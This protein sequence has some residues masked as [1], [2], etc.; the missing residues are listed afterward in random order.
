M[1]FIYPV[2]LTRHEDGS[3]TGEFPDL[4]MCRCEGPTLQ[5]ALDEARLAAYNWIDLELQEE[6]PRMPGVTDLEDIQLLPGQ[7]RAGMS[8]AADRNGRRQIDAD[9]GSHLW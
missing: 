5:D 6:D 9:T 2:V 8:K 4:Y 3:Y 7:E 1:T